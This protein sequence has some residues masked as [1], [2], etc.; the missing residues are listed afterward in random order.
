MWAGMHT[1]GLVIWGGS[2]GIWV[3]FLDHSKGMR[4]S[5]YAVETEECACLHSLACLS[6][7]KSDAWKSED[8]I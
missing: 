5:K 3:E 6:R 2:R 4:E 7:E 8:V 1:H